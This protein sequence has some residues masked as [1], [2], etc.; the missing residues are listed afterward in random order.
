MNKKLMVFVGL[1]GA[2]ALVGAPVDA[3]PKTATAAKAE[4]VTEF[5]PDLGA[6]VEVTP[7]GIRVQAVRKNAG[8]PGLD[9]QAGDL[10]FGVN[11]KHPDKIKDLHDLL[12]TGADNEDHDLDVIRRGAGHVH[13]MIF[14]VGDKMFV[15]KS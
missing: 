3:A 15:H 8:I 2:G 4:S 1:V 12:F 10:I 5:S 7:D 13:Y 9:L 14:H 11:G 6:V